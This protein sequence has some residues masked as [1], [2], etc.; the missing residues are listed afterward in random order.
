M[1]SGSLRIIAGKLGEGIMGLFKAG[2]S[3]QRLLLKRILC[4]YE[5]SW[6]IKCHR[7]NSLMIIMVENDLYHFIMKLLQVDKYLNVIKTL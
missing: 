6:T 4:I 1:I 3:R 5:V 7:W 2:P